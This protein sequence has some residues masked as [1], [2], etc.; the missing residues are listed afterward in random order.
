MMRTTLD[1]VSLVFVLIGG[2]NWGLVGLFSFDL[3][4]AILG[5]I[6]VLARIVYVLIGLSA[7]YMLYVAT[8]NK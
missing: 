8:K 2:I 4:D 5:T 6:P 3:V 1:W 7:L